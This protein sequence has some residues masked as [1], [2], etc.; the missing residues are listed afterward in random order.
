M[1]FVSGKNKNTQKVKNRKVFTQSQPTIISITNSV[2]SCSKPQPERGRVSCISLWC[3]WSTVLGPY[4]LRPPPKFSIKPVLT[5]L[6]LRLIFQFCFLC[7]S[8]FTDQSTNNEWGEWWKR[9]TW[10]WCRLCTLFKTLTMERKIQFVSNGLVSNFTLTNLQYQ[11]S[12]S[13]RLAINPFHPKIGIYI[14]HTVLFTFLLILTR[15]ICLTI[16][17]FLNLWLFPLHS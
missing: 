1:T 8:I 15:R 13:E 5:F 16:R 11:V 9:K 14:L 7:K 3:Q 2:H 17:S 6:N 12:R 4:L 10:K